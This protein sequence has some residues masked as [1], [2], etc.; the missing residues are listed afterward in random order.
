MLRILLLVHL[1]LM[2]LLHFKIYELLTSFYVTVSYIFFKHYT[3]SNC[4]T[5]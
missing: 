3:G 2:Q 5:V 4:G 1:L